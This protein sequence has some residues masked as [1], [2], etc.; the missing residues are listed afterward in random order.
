MTEKANPSSQNR[1]VQ[2]AVLAAASA[3]LAIGAVLASLEIKYET[4][5]DPTMQMIASGAVTGV[6]ENIL[7]FTSSIVGKIIQLLYEHCRG[8]EWYAIYLYTLHLGAA[9]LLW[10]VFMVEMGKLRGWLLGFFLFAVFHVRSLMLLQFTTTAYVVGLAG[11]MLLLCRQVPAWFRVLVG[12]SVICLC[13]LVRWEVFWM[14]LI[15]MGPLVVFEICASEARPVVLGIALAVIGY[16]AAK[17]CENRIMGQAGWSEYC[18]FNTARGS[19][20]DN[21]KFAYPLVTDSQLAKVG[22]SRNDLLVSKAEF[23]EDANIYNARVFN[24]LLSEQKTSRVDNIKYALNRTV[25]VLWELRKWTIPALAIL[26]WSL[27]VFRFQ[28]QGWIPISAALTVCAALCGISCNY[29]LPV[30]I[31]LPGVESV[32]VTCL[33]VSISRNWT[34]SWRNV[35]L[36]KYLILTCLLLLWTIGALYGAIQK[37]RSIGE[38]KRALQAQVAFLEKWEDKVLILMSDLTL[39]YQNASPFEP[40]LSRHKG[41]IYVMNWLSQSPLNKKKMMAR[42]QDN[43]LSALQN[44]DEYRIVLD[45]RNVWCMGAL[46]EFWREHY[47]CAM[48]WTCEGV[49]PGE[50]DGTK[51]GVYRMMPVAGINQI[52]RKDP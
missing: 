7:V 10:F 26:V 51:I 4:I 39:R 28:L 18:K 44:T 27:L 1:F 2:A 42:Q 15:Y 45:V 29:Y 5:D 8:I 11:V 24:A 43:V 9:A 41:G 46:V 23:L 30:R 33:W 35:L 36:K 34:Y 22:W 38:A 3:V 21:L 37:S 31:V 47:D 13:G 14:V 52:P 49:S 16:L 17:E 25:Q 40:G 48:Q 32:V 6:P 12:G 19:I 50:R 20:S